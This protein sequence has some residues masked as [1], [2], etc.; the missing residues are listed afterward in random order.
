MEQKCKMR[1][2]VMGKL[3]SIRLIILWFA[4]EIQYLRFNLGINWFLGHSFMDKRVLWERLPRGSTLF[5]VIEIQTFINP[6]VCCFLYKILCFYALFEVCRY[7]LRS[8]GKKSTPVDLPTPRESII[9]STGYK[10]TSLPVLNC[11]IWLRLCPQTQLEG[12]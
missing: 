8:A 6:L 3:S 5:D 9:D 4:I 2:K 1:R 10:R 11:C 12:K 7:L